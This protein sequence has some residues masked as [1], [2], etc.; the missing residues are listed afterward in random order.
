MA[1]QA[2]NTQKI[3]NHET[4][5]CL[6]QTRI[7]PV[8][9]RGKARKPTTVNFLLRKNLTIDFVI[10]VQRE[11]EYDG[12]Y[13]GISNNEVKIKCLERDYSPASDKSVLII[14]L[15]KYNPLSRMRET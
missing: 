11:Q 10:N 12:L 4:F 2:R 6:R 14:A 1:G 8:I 9:R 3:I 15:D 7:T 5:I 13:Y